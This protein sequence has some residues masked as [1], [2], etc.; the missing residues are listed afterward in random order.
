MSRAV[1]A[2]RPF[3]EKTLRAASSSFARF[4][5]FCSSRR[6]RA[7]PP[8]VSIQLTP[9]SYARCL[10]RS[11][12]CVC[13]P[14]SLVDRNDDLPE[15]P[16]GGESLIRGLDLLERERLRDRDADAPLFQ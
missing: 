4:C 12:T 16:A 1:A 3:S 11:S 15:L 9:S 5:A 13:A 7:S 8:V 2:P 14:D 6:P 10:A